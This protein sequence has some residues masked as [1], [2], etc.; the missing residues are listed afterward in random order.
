MMTEVGAQFPESLFD[1]SLK[2]KALPPF[3]I[4]EDQEDIALGTDYQINPDWVGEN[5]P[6]PPDDGIP[7]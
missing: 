2:C 6:P 1:E 3:D 5:P 4:G 7:F